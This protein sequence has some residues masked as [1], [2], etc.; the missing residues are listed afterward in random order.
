[1]SR[2]SFSVGF[3]GHENQEVEGE[4]GFQVQ[5]VGWNTQIASDCLMF[6]LL[7]ICFAWT[8]ACSETKLKRGHQRGGW[9]GP[10]QCE[11]VPTGFVVPRRAW[12][13][14]RPAGR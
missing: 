11:P 9:L 2:S 1:M 12:A 3:L 10:R 4:K 14:R 8:S 7:H 5:L 13:V 6:S